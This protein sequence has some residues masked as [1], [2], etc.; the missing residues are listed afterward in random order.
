M[1]ITA[2]IIT[3]LISLT[4]IVGMVGKFI[5][6]QT[7]LEIQLTQ[8]QKDVMEINVKLDKRDDDIKTLHERLTIIETKCKVEHKKG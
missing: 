6:A 8:I 7:K 1:E 4:T 3:T 5:S 2:T